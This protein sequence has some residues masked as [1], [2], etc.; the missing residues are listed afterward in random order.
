M[1]NVFNV[2]GSIGQWLAFVLCTFGI[3]IEVKYMASLGFLSITIG[4]VLFAVFTK[5]KYYKTNSKK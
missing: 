2:F 3:V 1:K 5:V 4:S